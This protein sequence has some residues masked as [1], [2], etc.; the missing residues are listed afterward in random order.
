M[1]NPDRRRELI[2]YINL[3]ANQEE[4]YSIWVEKKFPDGVKYDC[5][6]FAINLL[7]DDTGL[8]DNPLGM[9]G[10]V[11]KNET[12]AEAIRLL[13]SALD[14]LLAKAGKTLT[15]E[16][17]INHLEWVHVLRAARDA[18]RIFQ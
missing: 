3:L 16:A 14:N 8:A 10:S 4:Q 13:V 18:R 12:E 6:D 5:F 15:D 7:F 17:Y 9:I 1:D 2:Y 11:L